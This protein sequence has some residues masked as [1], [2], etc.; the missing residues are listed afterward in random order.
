MRIESLEVTRAI[1]SPSRADLIDATILSSHTDHS[2]FTYKL[3]EIEASCGDHK[4]ESL[5]LV[6]SKTPSGAPPKCFVTP[7]PAKDNGRSGTTQAAAFSM[8]ELRCS[9]D[10]D[11]DVSTTRPTRMARKKPAKRRTAIIETNTPPS[12]PPQ[13]I[14]ATPLKS[15]QD[16]SVMKRYLHNNEPPKSLKKE[17]TIEVQT[18]NASGDVIRME[19]ISADEICV[20]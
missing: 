20:D 5:N 8:P 3:S 1:M 14:Q 16:F 4:L 19:T 11:D 18:V 7:P 17:I 12:N 13:A 6:I 15:I 2:L 10:D 9:D